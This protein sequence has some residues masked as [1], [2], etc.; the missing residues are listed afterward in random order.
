MDFLVKR[1]DLHECRVADSP[2]PELEPGQALLAVSH[3]GLTSNNITYAVLGEA[4]NYWSFFPADEGWGRMPVWGFA[5]VEASTHD[6]VE[7]GTRVYGYFPPST[8]LV[9]APGRVTASGFTDVS[10]HRTALPSVYNRY[11]RVD[12]DPSYRPEREAQQMLLRPL[13]YTSF[14]LDDF[15]AENEFFGAGTV[16]LSSASSKT[17]HGTAF[18]LSRRGG[19]EVIG[20]TSSRSSEFVNGLGVYDRVVAYDDIESLQ[21]GT[22]VY[23]DMAGNA[24]T[25]RAV[26][27]H[28]GEGL[29]HSAMVGVTHHDRLGASADPPPGPQPTIFFAPAW[30][31]K[32]T[33]DWGREGLQNRLAEAW[34]PYVEW[35]DTWLDV[36]HERGPEALQRTYLDLLDGRIDPSA[37]L[38]LSPS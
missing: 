11:D 27:E 34:E 20:L 3:F 25:R 15:L 9:V 4:M 8:H 21:P 22:A 12:T 23:V 30:V 14:L 18:L 28:F 13:F 16:V 2:A 24:D 32:R 37:G 33:E 35:T 38:V 5:D 29:K 10:A 7:V 31:T 26:H 36:V 17:A 1:D 19:T 6:G